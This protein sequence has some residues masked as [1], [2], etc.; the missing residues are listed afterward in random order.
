MK[1]YR[2][3]G[4]K[5]TLAIKNKWVTGWTRVRYYCKVLAH[6][7]PLGGKIV[8]VLRSHM[9]AL[10]FMLAHECVVSSIRGRDV[11]EYLACGMYPLSTGIYFQGVTD[12]V[13]PVSRVKLLLPRFLTIRSD[14]EDDV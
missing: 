14:D 8:H 13:T 4:V 9:S 7:C 12:G 6:V 2:G 5:L 1:R 11:V 3:S 10:G